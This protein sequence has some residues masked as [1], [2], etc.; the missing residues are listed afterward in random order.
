MANQE[1]ENLSFVEDLEVGGEGESVEG[2]QGDGADLPILKCVGLTKVFR[3]FWMRSRVRAVDGVDVE[4]FRGEV[5][6]LLGPNGSGKSTTIKMIL[7][8]LHPTSGRVSVFGKRADDVATKKRIGYLPEESYLY[9]FLDARETLDY[10]GRLFHQG[11]RERCRR[12]DML[13]E[14]VGLETVGRRPV[15]EYSKGMQRRIGLAQALINDPTLLILDEPTNGLDPIGTRQIKDLIIELSRR[16]KA[17]LLCSHLLA[18]V[19]D[20]CH[21]VAI[22]F[23]GKIRAS[24]RV[25][26]LLMKQDLTAL[27]VSGIDDEIL[28]KIEVVLNAYGKRIERVEKPRQK[29]ESLFLEIVT[30]AQA[31]G[32]ATGGAT[33]GGEI[34]EFLVEDK[35]VD[36]PA[37][38]EDESVRSGVIER[39]VHGSGEVRESTGGVE[40]S[41]TISGEDAQTISPTS[42]GRAVVLEDTSM[43]ENLVEGHDSSDEP[44][45]LSEVDG[46]EDVSTPE[47]VQSSV[48]EGGESKDSSDGEGGS[49]FSEIPDGMVKDWL[50]APDGE[51]V[52]SHASESSDVADRK[53]VKRSKKVPKKPKRRGRDAKKKGSIDQPTGLNKS[54][55]GDQ[56]DDIDESPDQSFL[57][58]M[59]DVPPYDPESPKK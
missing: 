26:D 43:I 36:Q 25:D 48:E 13:L 58:A 52:V 42:G 5:F 44:C 19:E 35:R 28:E 24:G 23:G 50:E 41:E 4:V 2:D 9:P 8:L 49:M 55:E 7:G 46:G 47:V 1:S 56:K 12:I 32:V 18:D 53:P 14:M 10:Y 20:V 59:D 22:M 21:R 45:A 40:S 57:S 33:A 34:A 17:V 37:G 31:S 30:S 6:G 38:P 3:D 15:G 29:L 39:L 51:A 54:V 11:R 16:G 27:E